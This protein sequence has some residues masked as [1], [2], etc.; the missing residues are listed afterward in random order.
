[1]QVEHDYTE[2]FFFAKKT[3]AENIN[4]NIN[5]N[6]FLLWKIKGIRSK[7]NLLN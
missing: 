3:V 4:Y 2:L 7:E 6:Q 1:M 5:Y